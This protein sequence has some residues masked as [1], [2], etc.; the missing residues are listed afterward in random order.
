MASVN[1][2][3]LLDATITGNQ[4]GDSKSTEVF[5]SNF[6]AV[7]NVTAITGGTVAGTVQ[8]SADGTNWTTIATFTGLTAAGEEVE[9]ITVNVLPNVRCNM[10]YA[11]TT[12]DVTV[13]L[14]YDKCR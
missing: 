7:L 11:G 4:A 13:K 9:Q 8:H 12:A 10:T 1:T 2:I 5:Q 3:E 6:V 14:F